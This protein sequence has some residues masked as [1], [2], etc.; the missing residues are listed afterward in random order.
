MCIS[1]FSFSIPARAADYE[2]AL[3]VDDE[4]TQ[5][6]ITVEEDQLEVLYGED[7][8]DVAWFKEKAEVGIKSKYQIKDVDEEDIL[9]EFSAIDNVT[10]EAFYI[11]YDFWDWTKDNFEDKPDEEEEIEHVAKDPEDQYGIPIFIPV[12]VEDYIDNLDE[13]Q[14]AYMFNISDYSDAENSFSL[15]METLEDK[16]V[17]LT[18]TYDVNKGFQSGFKVED[19]D[20]HIVYEIGTP[21]IP[22]YEIPLFLG[23]CALSVISLIYIIRK[24][25]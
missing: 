14:V 11:Q 23:F 19:N 3:S 13:D 24:N 25:K 6:V 5:E 7:W 9:V 2:V 16:E 10:Y 17:V 21:A 20:G 4:I 1:L 15:E 22:G 8:E 12:S 18:W